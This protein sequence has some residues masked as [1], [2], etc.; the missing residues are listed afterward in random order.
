VHAQQRQAQ[1]EAV[2][3]HQDAHEEVPF[4]SE[5]HP[6]CRTV[7]DAHQGHD[8]LDCP[9]MAREPVGHPPE[10]PAD[11]LEGWIEPTPVARP[12][13]DERDESQTA[14]TVTTAVSVQ[15]KG[16]M[17][18]GIP[19]IRVQLSGLPGVRYPMSEAGSHCCDQ[20]GSHG[21]PPSSV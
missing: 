9:G 13:R 15:A 11:P 19:G 17:K 5:R 10:R 12:G 4:V 1:P 3:D 18:R 8:D 6:D 2:E 14:E 7:Q 21:G 20:Q 16:L